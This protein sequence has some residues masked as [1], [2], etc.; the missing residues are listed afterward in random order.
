MEKL[1]FMQEVVLEC[2]HKYYNKHLRMPLQSEI[3]EMIGV[4]SKATVHKHLH[5]LEKK[6][7]IIITPKFRRGIT[8]IKNN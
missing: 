5:N 4:N 3:K 8:F 1:T 2:L 6:G 7:Y